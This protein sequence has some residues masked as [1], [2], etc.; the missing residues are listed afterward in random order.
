[1]FVSR[2][3]WKKRKIMIQSPFPAILWIVSVRQRKYRYK[4]KSKKKE[5][6]KKNT[7]RIQTKR[8]TYHVRYN[9]KILPEKYW[10]IKHQVFLNIWLFTT[11]YLHQISKF[12]KPSLIF[13]KNWASGSSLFFHQISSNQNYECLFNLTKEETGMVSTRFLHYPNN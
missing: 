13:I 2:W 11:N 12:F 9:V 7:Y 4:K 3:K 8:N 6:K 5:R 10:I 1:M